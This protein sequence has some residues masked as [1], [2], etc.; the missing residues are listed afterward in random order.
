MKFK[1]E[2]CG[3]VS[4]AGVDRA[5]REANEEEQQTHHYNPATF[6]QTMMVVYSYLR[7][8]WAWRRK[9]R[10]EYLSFLAR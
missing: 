10:T 6:V 7:L 4:I 5:W 1:L 2:F 8:P 3:T 9:S